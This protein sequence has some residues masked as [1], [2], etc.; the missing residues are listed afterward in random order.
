MSTGIFRFFGEVMSNIDKYAELV[1]IELEDAVRSEFQQFISACKNKIQ[2]MESEAELAYW[3]ENY[4]KVLQE[5]SKP[6]GEATVHS[7]GK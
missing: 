6:S 5:K 4:R 3:L 7:D 2:Q 1:S